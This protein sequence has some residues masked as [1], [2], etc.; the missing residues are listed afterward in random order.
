M[1]TNSCGG[2]HT[3]QQHRDKKSK[4]SLPSSWNVT[5]LPAF[6]PAVPSNAAWAMFAETGTFPRDT[7]MANTHTLSP[8]ALDGRA[9]AVAVKTTV[10]AMSEI[11]VRFVLAWHA[12]EQPPPT[13]AEAAD[14]RI[15]CGT[16]DHN[17]M[18][19]EDPSTSLAC[20]SILLLLNQEAN[21]NILIC[22][23]V[24]LSSMRNYNVTFN[25]S[26]QNTTFCLLW[27]VAWC[28]LIVE[29]HPSRRV[30]R[31]HARKNIALL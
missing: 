22:T 13:A 29:M 20:W 19:V 18:Y 11:T 28:H 8:V 15:V 4:S 3:L 14:S 30:P 5:V 1:H 27:H 7:T 24:I 2:T 21:F 16:T 17:K 9:S 31:T 10:P 26:C 25:R 6:D 12:A 23:F